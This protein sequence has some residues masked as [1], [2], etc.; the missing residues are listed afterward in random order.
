MV[1]V[2]KRVSGWV[3]ELFAWLFLPLTAVS[4]FSPELLSEWGYIGIVGLLLVCG[5][6]VV[7][8][9]LRWRR[10]AYVQ[11]SYSHLMTRVVVM[12][13]NLFEQNC[14]IVIGVDSNFNT[15]LASGVVSPHSVHGQWLSSLNSEELMSVQAQI[16]SVRSQCAEFSDQAVCLKVSGADVYLLAYSTFN[17]FNRAQSTVAE[18]QTSLINLWKCIRETGETR[19]IAISLVGLGLSRLRLTAAESV[20]LIVSSYLL[21]QKESFISSELIICVSEERAHDLD[22]LLLQD[23]LNSMAA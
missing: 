1:R 18:L 4:M 6:Y 21:A 11:C 5:V 2:V 16:A 19:P 9:C 12:R 17:E 10:L 22:W 7:I 3:Q 8:R 14:P 23:L 20:T 15:D 13:A